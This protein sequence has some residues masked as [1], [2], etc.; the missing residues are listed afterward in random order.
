MSRDYVCVFEDSSH[1]W[2]ATVHIATRQRLP[3]EYEN[4]RMK[5]VGDRCW[6][7]MSVRPRAVE[8]P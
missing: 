4:E 7:C 2:K 1:Y 3:R 6:G 8:T 5:V